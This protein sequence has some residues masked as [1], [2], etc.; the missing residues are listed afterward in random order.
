MKF[1]E[2]FKSIA[3]WSVID[4][5]HF[6]E[7]QWSS[8]FPNENKTN[9]DLIKEECFKE[10]KIKDCYEITFET[11]NEINPI[12]GN[13]LVIDMY[14]DVF[15]TVEDETSLYK[16]PID[17]VNIQNI[18]FGQNVLKL[19][20][21]AYCFLNAKFKL[22]GTKYYLLLIYFI[23]LS[24]FAYHAYFTFDQVLNGELIHYVYYTVN[25]SI[26]MP[27][28]IFCFNLDKIEIDS[29]FKLTKN[30]LDDMHNL[31]IKT[32]F[33]KIEYLNKSN[34]WIDL[35]LE[36][37]IQTF[38]LLNKKCFK[39]K[40][41]IEYGR[42][43]FYFFKNKEVLRIYFN[44]TII[45]QQKLKV[46][47]FTKTSD[48]MQISRMNELVFRE[49]SSSYFRFTTSQQTIEYNHRDK[50]YF[51]K[52]PSLLFKSEA[53]LNDLNDLMNNFESNYNLRSLYLPSKNGNS[54]I[55]INDGLFEQYCNQ[56][57]N[58]DY[59]SPL[60]SNIR[61]LFIINN[62]KKEKGLGINNT[63]PDFSFDLNF[64][65]NEIKITNEDNIVKLILSLLN[66]LSLWCDL[67]AFDLGV[68][69]N[70]AYCKVK[71]IFM[72]AYRSFIRL[73]IYL[74]RYA[75]VINNYF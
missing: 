61:K 16:L 62:L 69:V 24:G 52:N 30:Y 29:N 72:F 49:K 45:H 15:S 43:Q 57:Q 19:L 6:N 21:M 28:T 27:E 7:D 53:D 12:G 31:R 14:Y 56:I 47:F 8:S 23:C 10:F 55:E 74:Y 58:I 59:S 51:V 11:N 26:K 64:L 73:D 22:N 25:D 39:I 1:I 20:V 37:R 18:L 48:G 4:K 65:K 41:K 70:Y 33:N 2:K 5:N 13:N 54:N 71:L 66:V 67:C 38:Y 42:N 44:R 40:Q 68:Y 46:Y 35:D 60:N 50:F 32:V 3:T 75:F 9:F 34:D 17:F 36:F 63:K